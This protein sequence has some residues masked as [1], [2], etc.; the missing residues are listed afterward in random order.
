MEREDIRVLKVEIS[1]V[2]MAIN[3]AIYVHVILCLRPRFQ[4]PMFGSSLHAVG[5]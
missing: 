1:G 5:C 4:V 3:R 2:Y